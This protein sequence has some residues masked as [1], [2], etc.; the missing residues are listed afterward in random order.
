MAGAGY[1][2][3]DTDGS[4]GFKATS[5][6][7]VVL[8]NTADDVI[9]I[10]GSLDL[11]ND[12]NP[13]IRLV[14]TEATEYA[15]IKSDI[16]GNMTLNPVGEKINIQRGGT[17]T[18]EIFSKSTD[19]YISGKQQDIDVHF[20][21]N[22]GGSDVSVLNLDA[23][24]SMANI[25]KFLSYQAV[26]YDLGSGMTSTITPTSSLH[27]LTA[28]SV[29]GDFGDTHI[30]SL[31]DGVSSGQVLQVILTTTTN[32]MNLLFNDSNLLGGWSFVGMPANS[33]GATMTFIWT[34]SAWSIMNTNSLASAS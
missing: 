30:I 5:D 13:H 17:N 21:V 3:Q 19:L 29:I 20:T 23:A 1:G 31:A 2:S 10:T 4:W 14:H 24:N 12:T 16:E 15:D 11:K 26:T 8:G 6:G 7:K 34:G 28:G 18:L 25:T 9:Q 27:L 22:D 32:N 33:Q